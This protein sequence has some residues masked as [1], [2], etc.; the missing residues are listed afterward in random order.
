MTWLPFLDVLAL[1]TSWIRGV[2]VITAGL[3]EVDNLIALAGTG[4]ENCRAPK[5]AGNA[6]QGLWG[7][8]LMGAGMLGVTFLGGKALEKFGGAALERIGARGDKKAFTAGDPVDLSRARCLPVPPIC[9]CLVFCRWF[10]IVP[11][12]I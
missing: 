3:A 5:I 2:D 12:S 1:A 7:D 6:T 8:A 10:C 4:L 9:R 11:A